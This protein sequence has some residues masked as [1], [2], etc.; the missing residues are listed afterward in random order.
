[1]AT[2]RPTVMFESGPVATDPTGEGKA[3]LWKWLTDRRYVVLVPNR[4]AHDGQGLSLEG[5][6]ESH[7]YPRRATN[8]FAV[9]EERRL[10]IRDR[11]RV[12]LGI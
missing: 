9:A 10:E 11:A 2:S 3:E 4:L 12:L 5:F 1:M 8:Y 7:L 6:L